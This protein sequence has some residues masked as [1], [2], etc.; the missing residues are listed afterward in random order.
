M[1]NPA[2]G[3]TKT[4]PPALW[5]WAV[6]IAISV[7]MFG[8][9]YAYDSVGPVADSLQKILGFSDTQIGTLNAIYSFPNIIMVLIGG[10]IVDRYGARLSTFV[11][12]PSAR[13]ARSSRPSHQTSASWQRAA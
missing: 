10:I 3:G 8:N 4:T 7:A 6:L 13:S 5:R 11:F 9:Y 1:S 2:T 12:T